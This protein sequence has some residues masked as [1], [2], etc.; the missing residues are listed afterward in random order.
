MR[1]I[2]NQ[3]TV[4][5]RGKHKTRGSLGT[6][7]RTAGAH[8]MCAL[9]AR[10]QGAHSGRANHALDRRLPHSPPVSFSTTSSAGWSCFRNLCLDDFVRCRRAALLE[11]IPGVHS[12][13]FPECVPGVRAPSACPPRVDA[14]LAP[15]PELT[16]GS[17][18]LVVDRVGSCQMCHPWSS[19]FIV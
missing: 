9:G 11:C 3:R 6:P 1:H 13:T 2:T 10:A 5:E 15:P 16:R 8:S 18:H 19:Q 7:W 14:D 17:M 4:V 12:H